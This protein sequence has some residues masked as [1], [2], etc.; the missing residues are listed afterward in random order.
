MLLLCFLFISLHATTDPFSGNTDDFLQEMEAFIKASNNEKVIN[1]FKVFKTNVDLGVIQEKEMQ[2]VIEVS[3]IMLEKKMTASPYFEDY[4]NSVNYLVVK[5][6]DEKTRQSWQTS[7]K[8]LLESIEGRTFT[9]YKNYLKFSKVFF[10]KGMLYYSKSGVNWEAKSDVFEMLYADDKPQVK[11]E[12]IMLNGVR[13]KVNITIQNTSGT[14]FPLENKWIGTT[15]TVDWKRH[16]DSDVDVT[17]NNYTVETKKGTYKASDAELSYPSYF[18]TTVLKGSLEDKLVFDNGELYPKF[19]SYDK[20]ITFDKLAEGVT[21]KGGFSLHGVNMYMKGTAES[22][23]TLELKNKNKTLLTS[24]GVHFLVDKDKK[25]SGASLNT[26]LHYN[27]E[28]ISHPSASIKYNAETKELNL[29]RGKKGL[30]RYP[31]YSSLHGMEIDVEK[32][33]F[34]VGTNEIMIGQ[35][36]QSFIDANKKVSFKSKDFFDSDKFIQYQNVSDVNPISVL[37]FLTEKADNRELDANIYASKLNS[38]FNIDNIKSMLY[39]LVADG[40]IIYNK[41]TEMITVKM[42]SLI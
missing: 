12:E 19:D 16:G 35:K 5:T 21:L 1:S 7:L 31:F 18:G 38:R 22:P 37:F 36:I 33:D 2:T 34:V 39:D 26:V 10:E 27:A 29:F 30:D 25:V 40:F 42:Q 9:K 32:I 23:C 8:G 20:D 24:E 13:K 28:T 3:N 11:F 14:Y 6:T 4:L 15:G 41:H 17:L